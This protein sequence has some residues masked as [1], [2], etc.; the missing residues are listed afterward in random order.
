MWRISITNETLFFVNYG[1]DAQFTAYNSLGCQECSRCGLVVDYK[2]NCLVKDKFESG[3]KLSFA[4]YRE[5]FTL[6]A[7]EYLMLDNLSFYSH[8]DDKKF[9]TV[10]INRELRRDPQYNSYFES[11]LLITKTKKKEFNSFLC[12]NSEL[13]GDSSIDQFTQI[14][15]NCDPHIVGSKK[16]KSR[17]TRRILGD[18]SIKAARSETARSVTSVIKTAIFASDGLYLTLS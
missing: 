2:V 18:V 8:M 11:S 10:Q 4:K 12:T 17:G 13:D 14:H 16:Q 7:T 6:V 9:A 5:L 15:E 3:H 1:K